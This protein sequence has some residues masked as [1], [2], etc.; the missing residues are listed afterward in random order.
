VVPNRSGLYPDD[1]SITIPIHY[2]QSMVDVMRSEGREVNTIQLNASSCHPNLTKTKEVVDT[3]NEAV[4]RTLFT[5]I[6]VNI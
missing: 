2:Q 3:A 6:S 4:G 1:S 5:R